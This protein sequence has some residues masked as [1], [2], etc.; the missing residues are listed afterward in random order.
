[1]NNN[2]NLEVMKA[3][4]NFSNGEKARKVQNYKDLNKNIIKDQIL[5]TGSSLMEHF[6]IL[7]LVQGD[8]EKCDKIIYNRG[9]AGFTTDEYLKNIDALCIDVHPSKIFINIGTNDMNDRDDDVDWFAHLE[10]NY[11]G[12]MT[13]ITSKLPHC[14]VYMMAY[15]P[16]NETIIQNNNAPMAAKFKTRSMAKVHQAN[17]MVK[18]LADKFG[19]TYIDA[20]DGLCDDSGQLRTELTVEGIHMYADGYK[21]VY[22]NLKEYL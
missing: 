15:Y 14:Q 3:L 21:I 13:I 20:N 19:A 2:P 16:I 12:I 5:F 7:E 9:V 18:S 11:T 1:M 8:E 22:E 6:P 17:D 10:E 4:E